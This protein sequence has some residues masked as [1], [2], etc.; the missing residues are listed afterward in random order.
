MTLSDFATFS[1]AVSGLA[2]TAS[3][4]Y[5]A[6]QTHQNAKHTKALIHQ[7][8]ASRS[9]ELS[10][11]AGSA[12][13]AAVYVKANGSLPTPEQIQRRQLQMLQSAFMLSFEESFSQHRNALL[14]EDVFNTLRTNVAAHF[15]NQGCLAVWEA[16]KVR[17]SAF[18][19]FVDETIAATQ[20]DTAKQSA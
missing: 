12:E 15:N 4:I 19:V 6:L 13:M 9:V 16:T 8:R 5:L 2:V 18:T 14:E 1:T 10:M 17:G 11:A 7:G 20:R 3:L